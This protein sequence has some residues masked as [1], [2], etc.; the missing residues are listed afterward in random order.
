M[1]RVSDFQRKL[2]EYLV[3]QPQTSAA[4]AFSLNESYDR[5]HACFRRLEDRELVRRISYAPAQW[6]LTQAGR[7]LVQ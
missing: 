4:L 2:L 1:T 3:H 5:V 6:E 7:E